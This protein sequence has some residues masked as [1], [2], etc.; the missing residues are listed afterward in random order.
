MDEE[1][2]KWRLLRELSK[3]E[4]DCV[5]FL[6]NWKVLPFSLSIPTISYNSN[7]SVRTQS[8]RARERNANRS[9]QVFAKLKK[10]KKQLNE[11]LDA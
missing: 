6:I 5:S 11:T 3:Q 10:K 2:S 4:E 8:K 7:E 1:L 9:T